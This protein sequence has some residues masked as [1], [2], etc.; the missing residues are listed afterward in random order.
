MYFNLANNLV[1]QITIPT[2]CTKLYATK[3][4][5]TLPEMCIIIFP[6]DLY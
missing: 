6:T 2:F 1:R 5:I 3:L 4:S